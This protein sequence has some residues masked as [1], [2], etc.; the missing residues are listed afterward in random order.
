MPD[1]SMNILEKRDLIV[2]LNTKGLIDSINEAEMTLEK[3]L[4]EELDFRSK[5]GDY[6]PGRSDDCQAVKKRL[7]ELAMQ[8]PK[9][10]EGKKMTVEETKAWLEKQRTVDKEVAEA[11]Q[12]QKMAEF[13]AGDFAIKIEM[14]R[15][16]LNDLRGVLGLRAAQI[17]FFASDVRTTLPVEDEIKAQTQGT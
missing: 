7:N 5:N 13:V 14:L 4:R 3:T 16:K 1:R 10:S 8:V 6:L 17:T 15:T 11:I 12:K 9:N 2:S